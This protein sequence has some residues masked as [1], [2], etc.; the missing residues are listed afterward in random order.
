VR[1]KHCFFAIILMAAAFQVRVPAIAQVSSIKGI[2]KDAQSGKPVEY[3]EILNYSKNKSTYSKGNGEFRL[4][5]E[6]GDTLLLHALGYYYEKII[7]PDSAL[8]GQNATSFFMTP[9]A[10]ELSEARIIGTGTY[11]DFKKAFLSLDRPATRSE[12]LNSTLAGISSM[13]GREAYDEALQKG[14]I[15]EKSLGVPILTRDEKE[16]I[17]LAKIEEKEAVCDQMYQKF[18]PQV[19]KQVTGLTDDDEIIRFMAYCNFKEKY[20]LAVNAYDLM[21]EIAR[22][23]ELYKQRKTDEN[24]RENQM[25]S[26][27]DLE[28][29][30]V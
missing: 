19:V 14:K 10:F 30:L 7:V 25:N 13:E 23:Y 16:R 1:Q 3:A 22:R 11:D 29:A 27:E 17:K 5:A 15:K 2:L 26:I 12:T 28:N 21:E 8:H 4:V 20:L 18:N 24:T 9:A 6:A